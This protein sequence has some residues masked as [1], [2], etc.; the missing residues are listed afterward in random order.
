M[1]LKENQIGPI[2]AGLGFLSAFG[3]FL[4]AYPYHLM[5]REQMNLFVFDW[6]YIRQTYRGWGWLARFVSDFLDQFF[7]L[8]VVGP[9]VIALLL[10]GIGTATYRICRHFLGRWPSLAIAAVF[11]IWSFFR[12]TENLYVTR[13]TVAV[14]AY[15]ALALLA[16]RCRKAWLKPVAAAALI[17]LAVYPVGSPYNKYY[18][19]AW[20]WPVIEYDKII[21]L[22]T[23]VYKENWDKI[24]RRQ[25]RK[26]LRMT[27][28]SYC[29]NLAHAMKGD[30]GESL[31]DYAQKYSNSLFMF[32]TTDL[33]QF[34]SSM[35]GEAWYHL[36]DMTVA[37]QSAIIGLQ[38]SPKHTG[39]RYIQRMAMVNLASGEQGAAQK[40]L[41]LLS[42][43]LFYGKW[44]RQILAGNPDP[45]T[46]AKIDDLQSKLAK[47]KTDIV[48]NA[49]LFRPVLLGLLEANPA[50]DL[51]HEYLLCYDL[52]TFDLEHF[53]EDYRPET[54]TATLY[55]EAVLIWLDS[56]GQLSQENAA[57][58]GVSSSTLNRLGRFMRYPENYRNTYWYYFTA[59]MNRQL[60]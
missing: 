24:I 21:G 36:G 30:L 40:Y 53:M 46:K 12:E 4:F 19:K 33:S 42:G 44:A 60:Q 55:H 51:A 58:Y 50:N 9:L 13:Y 54:D 56:Q 15:L 28:A 16:L 47:E 49:N 6:D 5:R 43:T 14:L 2:A 31:F 25:S 8:P 3:F 18:G 48:Y 20:G 10:L 11:F 17:A 41:R 59:E 27:E 37:E 7:S 39:A 23:E 52:L 1:K 32:I 45:E 22:D 34:S 57:K 35:V 26:D 29:Y 38:A